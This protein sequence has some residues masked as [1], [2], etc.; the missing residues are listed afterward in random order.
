M[1]LIMCGI[2]QIPDILG[3]IIYNFNNI[4]I[5]II[6]HYNLS[7]RIIDL[8]SHT[9][10]VVFVNCI[11]KWRDLQFKVDSERQIFWQ[12][13]SWQFYFNAQSFCQKSAER[14]NRRRNILFSIF[15]FDAWPGIRTLA[16]RTFIFCFD[17]WV[18][19][20]TLA[21]RL[22]SQHTTH[23][24][25]STNNIPVKCQ[26][27]IWNILILKN[28]V[29]FTWWRSKARNVQLV[30]NKEE[31]LLKIKYRVR[32]LMFFFWLNLSPNEYGCV[33]ARTTLR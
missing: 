30:G 23:K 22:I 24:T 14:G 26:L 15:R 11:H 7:V 28:A 29:Y 18:G 2:G 13:S 5:Y 32:Y 19:T 17:V 9:T 10:Y 27:Q 1:H 8:H 3:F 33:Y 25:T 16:L 4:H 12:T 20:R 31:N 6:G 21:F